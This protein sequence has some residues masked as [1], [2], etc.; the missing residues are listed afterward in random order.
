ML[1]WLLDILIGQSAAAQNVI[2]VR[3]RHLNLH[4]CYVSNW[5]LVLKDPVGIL[6]NNLVKEFTNGDNHG[7]QD[8]SKKNLVLFLMQKKKKRFSKLKCLRSHGDDIRS[9]WYIVWSL[10]HLNS[11]LCCTIA[12]RY[13]RNWR[14]YAVLQR[15]CNSIL[16]SHYG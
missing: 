7:N 2:W 8:E 15:K 4:T 1:A 6:L 11:F 12:Q 13:D 9:P 3:Q 16:S 5:V 14:T 10:P